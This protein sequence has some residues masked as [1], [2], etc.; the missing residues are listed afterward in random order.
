MIVLA[1]S[2]S[3][4]HVMA[5]FVSMR[6]EMVQL[7]EEMK[8]R[9]R[10]MMNKDYAIMEL[11]AALKA[12]TD[13]MQVQLMST[14]DI[15]ALEKR[16]DACE[17][18]NEAQDVRI[19]T[20]LDQ[21]RKD[22]SPPARPL[23]SPGRRLSSV[24]GSNFANEIS[25][26]GANAVI[27]WNSYT[28]GLTSFNCSGVGDGRLTCSG[29]MHAEDFVTAG[30]TSVDQLQVA[31][32]ELRAQDQVLMQHVGLRPPQAPPNQP[33]SAPPLGT[34]VQLYGH[35]WQELIRVSG[36][37]QCHFNTAASYSAPSG[38]FQ[39]CVKP[40]DAEINERIAQFNATYF[41]VRCGGL[42]MFVR[43]MNRNGAQRPFIA[44]A[45]PTAP[46]RLCGNSRCPGCNDAAHPWESCA[47]L[48]PDGTIPLDG[49]FTISMSVFTWHGT[50]NCWQ[51][52]GTSYT[53]NFHFT[54]DSVMGCGNN[55]GRLY[56]LTG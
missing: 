27:S 22:S 52:G 6:D 14:A 50:I 5:M 42:D 29:G 2:S 41:L 54:H 40:S 15:K 9:E 24:S 43:N 47:N 32:A 55:D 34:D 30:G 21:L 49:D 18:K 16:V 36:A 7:K 26:T 10:E 17:K 33:P 11:K 39:A 1:C 35:R 23:S 25:L 44:H 3:V 31:V 56:M 46:N 19:D 13:H 53:G 20:T 48:R 51:Q 28:P 4:V 12:K 45:C 8:E 37:S 38:T